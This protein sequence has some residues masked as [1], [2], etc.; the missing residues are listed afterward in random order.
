S[1]PP[2]HVRA[3]PPIDATGARSLPATLQRVVTA[4][5]AAAFGGL[6]LHRATPAS[7]PPAEQLDPHPAVFQQSLA[8]STLPAYDPKAQFA[9]DVDEAEGP[10]GL[11]IESI[12]LGSTPEVGLELAVGAFSGPIPNVVGADTRV[13]MLVAG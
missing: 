5:G 9:E 3:N 8:A 13:R 1:R 4:L 10:F 6:G 2:R 7:G 11:R 12:R